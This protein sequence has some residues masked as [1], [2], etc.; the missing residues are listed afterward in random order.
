MANNLALFQGGNLPAHLQGIAS[1]ASAKDLTD[2]VGTGFDVLKFKGKVWQVQQGDMRI[3]LLNDDGDPQPRIDVVIVKANKNVTKTYYDKGFSDGDVVKPTCWSND[4]KVPSPMVEKPQCSTCTACPKNVVGSKIGED[5]KTKTK[6][7]ADNRRL[8]V[9]NLSHA[10]PDGSRN[11][12]LLRLPWN[13]MKNVAEYARNLD[14]QNVRYNT[15]VTRLGF[16]MDKAYPAVTFEPKRWLT[17]DEAA[18][19]E[20]ML[21]DPLMLDSILG[22]SEFTA[23][24]A[25]ADAASTFD[26]DE[27]APAPKPAA[28]ATQKAAAAPAPKPAATAGVTDAVPPPA[29][30]KPAAAPAPAPAPAPEPIDSV[31]EEVLESPV[32]T[33]V[34]QATQGGDDLDGLFAEFDD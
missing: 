19:V 13:S 3:P 18:M 26:A 7:C 25:A 20:R 28:T 22:D 34:A 5:G 29:R 2:G 30:R 33:P 32:E 17:A 9:L 1:S 11:P 15:V 4:G 8:A 21:A 16:E 10:E 23:A 14:R 6:A 27:P 12:Q 24:P 31:A